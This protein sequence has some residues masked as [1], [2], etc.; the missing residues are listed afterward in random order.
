[1]RREKGSVTVMTIG[2]LM[3]LALLTVVVVNSSAAFLERQ[4]LNNLADGA[5]LAAADGLDEA[6]FYADR[7]VVLD[8]GEARR[9]VSDYLAG[10]G[11]QTVDVTT[12]GDTVTVHLER[13]LELALA[14]PGWTS[15]TTIV[16]DAT[17]QL[18]RA[19]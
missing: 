5:A 1:M 11:M 13:N 15:S 2:F 10:D 7:R 9:L 12:D 8:P 18:R 16:A 19:P 6:D 17:A 3:L 14:P 4:R